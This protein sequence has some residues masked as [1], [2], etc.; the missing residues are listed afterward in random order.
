MAFLLTGF[1]YISSGQ[2]LIVSAGTRLI[3][4][5][6][7]IVLS[8][9]LVNN[10]TLNDEGGTIIF[11]GASQAILGDSSATFMNI[12]VAG[13]S[14]TT[15][16]TPGQ[17]ISGKLQS[18]GTLNSDGNVTL[19]S[20][21]SG[22][23]LIDGGGT[24]EVL[25]NVTMERYLNSGFGYKYFSS[26]FQAAKVSEFGDDIDL[27]ASSTSF[28]RYD[29]ART[30]S[31]WVNYKT[32]SNNLDPM[33]GY[34]VNMGNV[35]SPNTVDVTGVVNNG[36]KSLT[37]FNHNNSY[38]KG[39]SLVGNPYPS[40]IDWDAPS[41]WTKSNIDNALFFFNAST[42]DQ[43]GGTYS[44]YI[45]GISNDGLASNIIPSMQGF[46]V[47]VSDGSFPVEATLE[48]NNNVRVTNQPQP[49]IK[50]EEVRSLLRLT[51]SFS[52]N[53]DDPD[54]S[55][56]YF[57]DKAT[58]D[59]DGQLD[60]LKLLN[61]DPGVPNLYIEIPASTK[62]SIKSLPYM[63]DTTCTVPIGLKTNKTGDVIFRARDIE[64]DFTGISI[65]LTDKVAG[66]EQNLLD[67]QEYKITLTEGEYNDRF[68]LNLS[69]KTEAIPGDII[70]DV[71]EEIS[72]ADNLGIYYSHGILKANILNLEGGKG[73]LVVC[74][75]LG[76]TFLINKFSGEGYHEFS[77]YLKDGIYITAVV[78]GNKRFTKKILIIN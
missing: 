5:D 24:G 52:D 28:Y 31:G 66:T 62:T 35:N 18:N 36:T 23:A 16:L 48:M 7:N 44:T 12:T 20:T 78:T 41:G 30:S 27:A 17:R 10:G 21:P 19:S 32:A 70:N 65:S 42:G 25:G 13:G 59:F 76:Q 22:T 47:H 11:A 72:P 56:I 40:P 67:S 26:P 39:Y 6:G 77:Q 45:D 74:N 55:V 38:T 9:N 43:Y 15:V 3:K 54:F 68:F 37:L 34:A 63:S 58:D 60:A 71:P 57:D 46:F 29:E 53:P 75:I 69:N 61:T 64:G 73:T 51:A 50:G 8:G 33:A 49:F 14:T 1:P 2:G 4:S